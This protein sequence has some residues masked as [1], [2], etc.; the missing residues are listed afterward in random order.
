M[1]TEVTRAVDH[2]ANR[3][4]AALDLDDFAQLAPFLEPLE[5]PRGKVLYETGETIHHAYFPHDCVMSL[6]TVM[7]NGETV[8]T[9]V[10]GRE[11]VL[12]FCTSL[13][14]RQSF[15]RYIVQIP[16]TASR[17]PLVRLR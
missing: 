4:L 8:E 16:G 13:V 7:Q 11:G 3:L 14:T 5:L 12:G 15:G 17:I 6:V 9:A 2:R 10:F 1:P